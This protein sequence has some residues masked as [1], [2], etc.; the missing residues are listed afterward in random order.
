LNDLGSTIADRP[1]QT[2]RGVV[3]STIVL[4]LAGDVIVMADKER[5]KHEDTNHFQP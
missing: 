3:V 1:H 5:R 4:W 2:R